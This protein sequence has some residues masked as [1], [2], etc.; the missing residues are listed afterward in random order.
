[1]A[2][3]LY[4]SCPKCNVYLGVVVPKPPEQVEEIPISGRCLRCGYRLAWK[5][6]LG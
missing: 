5:I 1:L 2:K 6:I 3:Y 4:R